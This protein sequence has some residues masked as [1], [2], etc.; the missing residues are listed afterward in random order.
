MNA[1]R[2]PLV[3]RGALVALVVAGVDLVVAL[4]M[5]D[6]TPGQVGIVDVFVGALG[7]AVLVV[8]TRGKVTPVADPQDDNGRSLT[9][10]SADLP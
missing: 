2:E 10:S 3:I 4:G 5:V 7:T 1:D 9:P 8:W 6:W